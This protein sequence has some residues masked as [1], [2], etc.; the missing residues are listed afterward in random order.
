[1][2][3]SICGLPSAAGFAF[4][5]F[6]VQLASFAIVARTNGAKWLTLLT[7]LLGLLGPD[8]V[9][10]LALICAFSSSLLRWR[11]AATRVASRIWP[12]IGR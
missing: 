12:A 5:N 10:L 9:C 8:I 7:R 1:M 6:T 4:G 3:M 2:A 11:G